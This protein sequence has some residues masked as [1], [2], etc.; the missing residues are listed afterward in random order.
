MPSIPFFWMTLLMVR[1]WMVWMKPSFVVAPLLTNLRLPPLMV[2]EA[3]P[4]LTMAALLRVG[5]RC[6]C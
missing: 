2:L 3:V 6:C 4:A 5:R 1:F